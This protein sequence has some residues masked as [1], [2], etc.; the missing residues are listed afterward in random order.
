MCQKL[1]IGYE[2]AKCYILDLYEK[3]LPLPMVDRDFFINILK[4][5][6]IKTETRGRPCQEQSQNLKEKM[7]AFYEQT[8]SKTMTGVRPSYNH[9][10]HIIT[11]LADQMATTITTNLKTNFIKYLFKYVNIIHKE[12]RSKLIRQEKNKETRKQLY[13]KLTKDISDLKNDLIADTIDKSQPEYHNWIRH[14]RPLLL[15]EL[16]DNNVAYDLKCQPM[17]YLTYAIYINRQ[18]EDLDHRPNQ[19]FPQR[20]SHIPHFILLNS[21]SIVEMIGETG[22]LFNEILYQHPKK[23]STRSR[24]N[25]TYANYSDLINRAGSYHQPIW[26]QILRLDNREKKTDIFNQ[27]PYEFYN[28][29]RT[30]GFSCCLLFIHQEH[31]D[32]MNHHHGKISGSNE[33]D[34]IHELNHDEREFQQLNDLSKEQCDQLI[35]GKYRIASNDPG[36][37]DPLSMI[38]NVRG[39]VDPLSSESED[40]IAIKKQF[41]QYS[42]LRRKRETYTQR[43]ADILHNE[44]RCHG[45]FEMEL[46]ISKIPQDRKKKKK[47]KK[48]K[49]DKKDEKSHERLNL[50][51]PLSSRTTHVEQFEQFVGLKHQVSIDTCSFY[52]QILFRKMGFR[53][54][55]WTLQSESRLVDEIKHKYLSD[56]E[57]DEGYQLLILY[58]NHSRTQMMKGCTPCPGIGLKRMLSKYFK[59]LE[60]DEYC[61]SIIHHKR[62]ERM[63]NLVVRRGHHNRKVHKILTLQEDTARRIFINR[64]YNASRNILNIGCEYLKHQTRPLAFCR[65]QKKEDLVE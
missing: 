24:T 8:F 3:I 13:H 52:E 57:L 51:K 44:K 39:A 26:S 1:I 20:R 47:K 31:K 11:E 37:T 34:S 18:I 17:N 28:Q 36:E 61:T 7:E 43:S 12:P 2:F 48:Q 10:N 40:P 42:A 53:R 33:S 16:I 6:C 41:F 56:Q 60:V 63:T 14:N 21:S 46:P 59:I 25:P 29:I 62:H 15:P 30:D 45:V 38:S 65:N 49:K 55:V 54:Y 5:I 58:G 35:K 27:Y 64:D 19:I 50:P 23:P 22:N 32:D 9:K 4:T